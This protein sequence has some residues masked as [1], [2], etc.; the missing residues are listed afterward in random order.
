[1]EYWGLEPFW[2]HRRDWKVRYASVF[3]IGETSRSG[4]IVRAQP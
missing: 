3:K 4:A 2:G 1:L